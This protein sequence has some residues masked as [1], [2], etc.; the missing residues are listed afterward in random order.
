MSDPRLYQSIR[1]AAIEKFLELIGAGA[2]VNEKN[3]VGH[4]PLHL[5]LINKKYKISKLL[6]EAGA[7]LSIKSHD[8]FTAF[9]YALD[10]NNLKVLKILI[11]AGVEVS[12]KSTL[13]GNSALHHAVEAEDESMVEFLLESGADANARNDVHTTVL[14]HAIN[15]G[16]LEIVKKLI[17]AGADVHNSGVRSGK[18]ALHL[19]AALNDVTTIQNLISQGVNVNVR[20]KHGQ[21]PLHYACLNSNLSS[22][23]FR[24]TVRSLLNN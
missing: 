21:T 7:D 13:G 11:Q 17:A 12:S 6:V 20:N 9:Q 24:R 16:N 4:T 22:I 19:A 18:T 5:A 23:G 8:G 14:G 3:S 10:G 2:D 15:L 1:H